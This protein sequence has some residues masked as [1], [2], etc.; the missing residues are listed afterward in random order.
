[1]TPQKLWAECAADDAA[2]GAE[3]AENEAKTLHEV[4]AVLVALVAR[5]QADEGIISQG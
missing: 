1:M 2:I 3:R 5:L 4:A